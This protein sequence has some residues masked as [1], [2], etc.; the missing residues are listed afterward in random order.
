MSAIDADS[1]V[2]EWLISKWVESSTDEHDYRERTRYDA[3][4]HG[5]VAGLSVITADAEWE[6]GCYSSWT[7]EDDFIMRAVISTAVGD[8]HF[9]YG[10]WGDFPR[11]I[12]ELHE[13][14]TNDACRYEADERG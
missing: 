5:P 13:Y 6:C 10:T 9:E 4:V 2:S 14:R 12:E 3:K 8:I 1:L 11:F 7:R